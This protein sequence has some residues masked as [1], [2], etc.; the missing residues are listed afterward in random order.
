MAQAY[1]SDV[2]THKLVQWLGTELLSEWLGLLS[3]NRARFGLLT[4]VLKL[5]A[6]ETGLSAFFKAKVALHH[7]AH[8]VSRHK[9]SFMLKLC[10]M[11]MCLA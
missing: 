2:K 10:I 1:V 9:A 6:P 3:G 11:I 8:V 4:L 7:S 5:Y